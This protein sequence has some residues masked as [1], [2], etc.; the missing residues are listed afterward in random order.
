[1]LK[2]VQGGC[3]LLAEGL[4]IRAQDEL[5]GQRRPAKFFFILHMSW[6][7]KNQLCVFAWLTV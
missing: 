3:S 1:M 5:N 6:I 4:D 2:T 7:I